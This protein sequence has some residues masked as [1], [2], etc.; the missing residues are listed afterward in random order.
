MRWRPERGE[1]FGLGS[2][3]CSEMNSIR[4]EFGVWGAGS[5]VNSIRDEFGVWGAGSEA[6]SMRDESA[7]GEK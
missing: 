3:A 1:G 7:C 4:D 5:E 6:N 2:V